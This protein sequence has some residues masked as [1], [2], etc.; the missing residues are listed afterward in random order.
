M[1]KKDRAQRQYDGFVHAMRR[2]KEDRAQHGNDHSCSCF[3]PDGQT[4][5]RFANHPKS[6]S[7]PCCG[8]PRKHFN[9]V[10]RQEKRAATVKE[11]E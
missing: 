11:W 7:G 6:C 1:G 8:N 5:S 2:I 9:A 3:E 4:L 10:T